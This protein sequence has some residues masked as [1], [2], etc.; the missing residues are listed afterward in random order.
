MLLYFCP[1][2]DRYVLYNRTGSLD[3][4]CVPLG[5]EPQD[6]GDDH[7]LDEDQDAVAHESLLIATLLFGRLH[8]LDAMNHGLWLMG[9]WLGGIW[10]AIACELPLDWRNDQLSAHA[11]GGS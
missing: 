9:R 2:L 3:A 10:R 4:R 1:A 5:I 6:N 11:G 7:N 8:Q